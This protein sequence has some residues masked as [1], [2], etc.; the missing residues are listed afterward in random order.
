MKSGPKMSHSDAGFPAAL[1]PLRTVPVWD[2]KCVGLNVSV[3]LSNNQI[4]VNETSKLR[5]CKFRFS[6]FV[7]A[8]SAPVPEHGAGITSAGTLAE[9]ACLARVMQEQISYDLVGCVRK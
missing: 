9:A 6:V 2:P 7:H 5:C 1:H 3:L 4:Y 8:S